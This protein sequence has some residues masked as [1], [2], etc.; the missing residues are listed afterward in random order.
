MEYNWNVYKVFKNGKRAKAPIANF[1]ASEE[2]YKEYFEQQVKKN[3]TENLK[4]Q[5]FKLIRSDLSQE[6]VSEVADVAEEK[7][8]RKKNR[9]LA[10]LM[11]KAN[12]SSKRK[13]MGG[14]VYYSETNWRWQ[15]AA[16][17]AGTSKFIATL[18]P[19]FKT[20]KEA[21]DWIQNQA[22]SFQK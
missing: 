15:W 17:E 1:Y 8:L 7:K 21:E 3:F 2:T 11:R 22:L 10:A 19:S 4:N 9:V 14:L 18:S 5:N 13:L 20:S 6:R 16:L 12:L